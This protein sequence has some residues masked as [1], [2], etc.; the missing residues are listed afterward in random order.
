MTDKTTCTAVYKVQEDDIDLAG[1]GN[2]YNNVHDG[3]PGEAIVQCVSS[4]GTTAT[5]S[6]NGYSDRAKVKMKIKGLS[7]DEIEDICAK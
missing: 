7:T 6:S 3:C 4:K 2:A 1:I 5:T